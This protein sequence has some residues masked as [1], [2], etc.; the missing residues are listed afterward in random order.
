MRNKKMSN[1]IKVGD[2]ALQ[3]PPQILLWTPN[4]CPPVVIITR[5]PN[6]DKINTFYYCGSYVPENDSIKITSENNPCPTCKERLRC[7]TKR[8]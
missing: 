8:R 1:K 4:I 7:L 5:I 2:K 3:K 6:G